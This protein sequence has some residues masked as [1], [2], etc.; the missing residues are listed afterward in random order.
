MT[1][2]RATTTAVS[3]LEGT[4]RRPRC[5]RMITNVG[6]G[7]RTCRRS[8]PIGGPIGLQDLRQVV[9]HRHLQLVVGAGQRVTV[10]APPEEL[11]GV[12]KSASL[13]LVVLDLHD[14]FGAQRDPGEVL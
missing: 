2:I 9:P 3:T 8:R 1:R 11:A 7:G 5:R 6:G 12:T 14:Q 13:E 10:G 4:A